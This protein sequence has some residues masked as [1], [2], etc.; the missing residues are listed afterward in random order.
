MVK[1]DPHKSFEK[2]E[3]WLENNK[4]GVPG[5]NNDNSSL[6]LEHVKDLLSG[7]LASPVSKRGSRSPIRVLS[8]AYR[9]TTFS[10]LIQQYFGAERTFYSLTRRECAEFFTGL[11]SGHIKNS[12]GRIA[13]DV[14]SIAKVASAWFK[15]YCRREAEAGRPEPKDP[16]VDVPKAANSK[17]A[18]VYLDKN[19][20][21]RLA[22][23][24][25]AKYRVLILFLFDSGI[26]APTELL[27]VRVCD[28]N[29]EAN[30]D[31]KLN[32]RGETSKTFGRKINLMHSGNQLLSFINDNGLEA[33]DF[34]F[35][36][37]KIKVTSAAAAKY[38]RGVAVKLFGDVATSGRE[39]IGK[40]SL[41]DFR[42]CSA[43]YWYQ[44]YPQL[45]TFLYRFGWKKPEM[46]NY[47][48]EFL[49]MTDTIR[50]E[51]LL[52]GKA[53][54]DIE[55][56]LSQERFNRQKLEEEMKVMTE[57]MEEFQKS[58]ELL[59]RLGIPVSTGHSN[60]LSDCSSRAPGNKVGIPK[61]DIKNDDK[62]TEG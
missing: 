34:I 3:V 18:W 28:V 10:R 43:C 17:P 52:K 62:N 22:E 48:S 33:N 59:V 50:K 13:K 29:R 24:C 4:N 38:Y 30:G 7:H 6:L 32:I 1:F 9:L 2:L 58:L 40:I 53:L 57:R 25:N 49:G 45:Q 8:V 20:I 37:S 41:Y 21:E 19:Q 27:N 35:S 54:T 23:A 56:E 16:F 26:R 39:R 36:N 31:V 55:Q 42:H 5:L 47:Y 11:R 61:T 15:W 46:A 51:D 14:D 60:I 12:H 44:E